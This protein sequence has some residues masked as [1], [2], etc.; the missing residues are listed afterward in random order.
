MARMGAPTRPRKRPKKPRTL[1]EH[2][3]APTYP[4]VIHSLWITTPPLTRGY[5]PGT[6]GG[7]PL[8]TGL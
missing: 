3:F 6:P 2:L 5:V 4:Q 8:S 1:I 7:I